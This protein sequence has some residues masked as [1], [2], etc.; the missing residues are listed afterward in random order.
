M[1]ESYATFA[2][3]GIHCDPIII[4]KITSRFGK[5]LDAPSAN[6]QRV[7]SEDVADGMNQA[8]QPGDGRQRHRHP[9]SDPGVVN[10]AG[11]TGTINSNQAVWFNGYTSEIAGA[12]MI[13][14]DPTA[15]CGSHYRKRAGCTGLPGAD[16]P[17]WLL[18]G[19]GSGDAGLKIWKQAMT[20]AMKGKRGHR[21]Q[22]AAARI[23]PARQAGAG[24]EPL[25]A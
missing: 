6:C 18:E 19:S 7:I 15:R 25:R 16:P 12:A 1:A 14:I 9:G 2:A 20:A 22:A 21:L 23:D 17:G 11:K 8:A 4:S 5:N 13:A 24:A 3:R 10:Q